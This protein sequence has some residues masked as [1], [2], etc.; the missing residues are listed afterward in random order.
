MLKLLASQEP[1]ITR[2]DTW[3]AESNDHMLAVNDA[4]GCVIVARG[5]EYQKKLASTAD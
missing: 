2:V 4:L 1:Q 5:A 3:N